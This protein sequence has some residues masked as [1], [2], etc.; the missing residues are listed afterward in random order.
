[1]AGNTRQVTAL[2]KSIKA[3]GGT[4][5]ELGMS[6]DSV[7]TLRVNFTPVHSQ[8]KSE[9]TSPPS[10]APTRT[11]EQLAT[12]MDNYHRNILFRQSG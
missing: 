6:G 10:G 12:E 11:K 5:I 1:M 2:L 3:M 4:Q 9:P 7:T 8:Q